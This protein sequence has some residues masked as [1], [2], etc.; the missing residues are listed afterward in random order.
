M[1]GGDSFVADKKLRDDNS[2]LAEKRTAALSSFMDTLFRFLEG[3][4]FLSCGWRQ[5]CLPIVSFRLRDG[6]WMSKK[7]IQ[8]D[9]RYSFLRCC[10]SRRNSRSSGWKL[11]VLGGISF[12]RVCPCFAM[13]LLRNGHGSC[14]EWNP[15]ACLLWMLLLIRLNLDSIY[16]LV[17]LVPKTIRFYC[18]MLRDVYAAQCCTMQ[19][20]MDLVWIC[21]A[22]F[23]V[24]SW[25]LFTIL[26]FFRGPHGLIGFRLGQFHVR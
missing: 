24:N 14:G 6:F 8:V 13:D 19:Y 5:C 22:L 15:I 17:D 9:F 1:P 21:F 26:T 11:E 18:V 4:L 12:Q 3:F 2:E 23:Y 10:K 20:T 25:E 16:T 7:S